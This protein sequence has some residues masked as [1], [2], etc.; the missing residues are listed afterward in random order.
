[1][2]TVWVPESKKSETAR[3]TKLRLWNWVA[4]AAIGAGVTGMVPPPGN[5]VLMYHSIGGPY[6]N[7]NGTLPSGRLHSDLSRLAA[8]YDL[9][10]LP[11]V[12]DSGHNP[13]LAVTFDDGYA[14]IVTEALPVLE[15]LDV[16]ATVFV[17]AD[18]VGE[19]RSDPREY[20]LEATREQMLSADQ[21]W[22]LVDH[23][24]ITIGS[25]TRTHPSL[26]EIDHECL[27]SEI[28]GARDSLRDRYGIDTERFCYP[29][30]KHDDRSRRIVARTQRLG[31]GVDRGFIKPP[32]AE[33]HR[34]T[35]P[36]F[37]AARPAPVVYWETSG[38]GAIASSTYRKLAE[39]FSP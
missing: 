18:L 32:V 39:L 15:A 8:R 36:R 4:R 13:R 29:G 5:A 33:D 11:A 26:T 7:P 10:D 27:L 34:T 24:L 37:N 35:L 31:V 22:R 20:G 23:D 38:L 6:G 17:I 25:H 3:K 2:T 1:V 21:M 14:D 12:L 30:G 9:V 19:D 28:V 16:P